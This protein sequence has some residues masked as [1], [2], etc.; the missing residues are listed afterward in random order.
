MAS[1]LPRNRA[2]RALV[3][4]LLALVTLEAIYVVA[5]NIALAAIAKKFDDADPVGVSFD[6]GYSL[7]PG[8]V[9]LRGVKAH[10]AASGGWSVSIPRADAT[11]SIW[12][13]VTAPRVIDAIAAD[14]DSVE[15]GQRAPTR[16]SNGPM[17]VVVSDLSIDGSRISFRADADVR[18]VTLE[19]AG[20]VLARDVRGTIALRVAPV[21]VD[22]RSLV[23]T[24]S[25]SIAL[26]GN[27]VSL[28][29]L[30]SFG[31]LK[32]TQEPGTL[33]V[34]GS[35][36]AGL[37][38]PG[39]EIR[40]HTS[41]ATLSDD[42]GARG[43]FPS[44]LDVLVRVAPA[45]PTEL[46]LAVETPRLVFAGGKSAEPP[47]VFE[48]FEL[49][50]PAGSS[51]LKLDRLGMTSLTW[52]T[53][54]ATVHE[55]AT[56]L[57]SPANGTLRF[58]LGHETELVAKN[59]TIHA[60][61]VVVESPDVTDRTPFEASLL[62]EGLSVS[63]AHGISLQGPLHA[64]GP[65][66]LPVLEVFV[67]SPSIRGALGSL[68]HK[69][70][71]LD[72]KMDRS[73]GVLSLDDLTLNAA[74]LAMR[75]GYRRSEASSSGAFLVDDGTLSVGIAMKDKKES[76]VFGASSRWLDRALEKSP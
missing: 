5:V 34:S 9:H 42:R 51:D 69:S 2:L 56:S 11:F 48:D 43:D 62:V 13:V 35:L 20:D 17:H 54:R 52:S 23:E 53:R 14:V 18:G 59:G 60:T 66:A 55:G 36:D 28:A 38:G 24:T 49:T 61:S 6:R 30:A 63:R 39:S 12:R 26:D 37:L 40:A 65:D 3:V 1:L 57:A 64:S 58:E 68:A 32:T 4:L 21:D 75:G 15:I 44:G 8:S 47:D 22:K 74:G 73:D 76:L 41:R 31:S 72:A 67:T 45:T 33:H 27:F 50:V 10:G 16:K 7:V 19:N 70:F 71:T 29:P 46:Q 25:G